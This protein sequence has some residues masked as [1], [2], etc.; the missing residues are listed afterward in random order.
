MEESLFN[1]ICTD[2]CFQD[3]AVQPG[4]MMSSPAI[5]Y[6]GSVFAFFSRQ[7]K[8]VFRLGKDFVAETVDFEIRVFNPFKKRPPLN[9]WF[10]VG[11]A[12][13]AAWSTLAARALALLKETG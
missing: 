5:T 2:M 6:E 1:N 4:K 12:D 13:S 10:E 3:P 7:K 9:G 11:Y 8:M